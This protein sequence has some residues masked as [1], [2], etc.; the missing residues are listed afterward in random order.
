MLF[1]QERGSMHLIPPRATEKRRLAGNCAGDGPEVVREDSSEPLMPRRADQVRD[2]R[3]PADE[4]FR[5][6]PGHLSGE[7]TVRSSA[8]LKSCADIFGV[9]S[10][11]YVPNATSP[12]WGIRQR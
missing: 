10:F 4:I 8:M 11:V 2:V 1:L 5:V 3:C 6:R 7:Y 12:T 9:V